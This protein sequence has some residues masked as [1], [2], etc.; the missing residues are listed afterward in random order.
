MIKQVKEIRK[1]YCIDSDYGKN[2]ITKWINNYNKNIYK[3]INGR[4]IYT[5]NNFHFGKRIC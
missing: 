2:N 5:G 1:W 3:F 4:K